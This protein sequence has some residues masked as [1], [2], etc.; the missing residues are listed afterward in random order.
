MRATNLLDCNDNAGSPAKVMP[1]PESN[2]QG[3]YH[4]QGSQHFT[5]RENVLQHT[6]CWLSM[7]PPDDRD[8][9]LYQNYYENNSSNICVAHYPAS[10]HNT[11][12]ANVY[13]APGSE[14][15][16]AAK[17][18]MS[19]AGLSS[20]FAMPPTVSSSSDRKSYR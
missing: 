14:W 3:L 16:A 4:D 10:N 8:I 20:R 5:D 19:N 2:N 11:L 6:D 12:H 15:P 9:S 1:W 18:I 13:V 17:A 7:N